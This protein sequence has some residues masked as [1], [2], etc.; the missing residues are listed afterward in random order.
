MKGPRLAIMCGLPRSGKT[1]YARGLQEAGWVRVCPDDIRRALHGR[2]HYPP[3]EPV[4][5]ANAE[6]AVR[7]LL[8]GGHAVVVDATHTTRA[9]RAPWVRMA[10][11]LGLRLEAYVLETPAE[12]C[13]RRSRESDDPVPPE[14]IDR[15]AEQWEPV[16]EDGVEV[17]TVSGCGGA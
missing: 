10:R 8:L 12:E 15:M 14:V 6:L 4:V 5:W 9:R 3:A 17:R 1:T 7:S 11:E 16:E 2:S 13:R